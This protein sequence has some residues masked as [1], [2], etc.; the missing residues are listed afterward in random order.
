MGVRILDVGQ[1]G[2]DHA[3]ITDFL[4][5]IVSAHV[6]AAN[7]AQEAEKLLQQNQYNLVLVNRILDRDH[8]SGIDLIKHLRQ[9]P[10]CPPLMLVSNLPDA[11]AKA[12]AAGALQGFGKATIHLPQVAEH[13]RAV[14]VAGHVQETQ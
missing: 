5:H 10:N 4:E 9:N 7:T 6:D 1:C 11:Q 14:L 13:L 8:S 3:A 2:F 12:V